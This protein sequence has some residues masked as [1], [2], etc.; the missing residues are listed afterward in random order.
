[1][2]TPD[3][4]AIAQLRDCVRQFGSPALSKACLKSEPEDF[5]VEE[6]PSYAP[7]GTGEHLFLWIQKR[8]LSSEQLKRHIVKTLDIPGRDIGIAGNKDRRAVTRQFVSVPW[9]SHDR[10]AELDSPAVTVLSNQ[11]HTNKLRTGHLT[12]NRFQILLRAHLTDTEKTQ[13]E[14]RLSRLKQEGFANYFGPQRFGGGETPRLGWELLVGER[15]RR[16][17]TKQFGRSLFRL[18][19]SAVQS[20]VFN[21][22]VAKRVHNQSV[23]RVATGDVAM[24]RD[25]RTHFVVTDAL[26]EQKRIDD[27]ELVLTGPICGRKMTQPS[28]TI[29]ELEANALAQFGLTTDVF[30]RYPK[31][32][33]GTRRPLLQWPEDLEW[34]FE[35]TG[36]RLTFSL[37]PGTYATVLLRE[38]V[39]NLV[40]PAPIADSSSGDERRHAETAGS[41]CD[42]D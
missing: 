24:F 13:C 23:D 15:S 27:G 31:L 39:E 32:T 2:S 42:P 34:T 22:V 14:D 16:A 40:E 30:N 7:C 17:M 21:R 35:P 19:L 38:L 4:E 9:T 29:A 10:I 1:M 18:S 36:L 5:V 3:F 8:D 33:L 6:L 28:D 41:D 12:G 26:A 11:R 20:A 37:K 25:R